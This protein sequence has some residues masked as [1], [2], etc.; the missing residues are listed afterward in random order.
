V[1]DNTIWFQQ[2][3]S[4]AVQAPPSMELIHHALVYAKELERIV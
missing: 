4:S 1:R 2:A 3:D